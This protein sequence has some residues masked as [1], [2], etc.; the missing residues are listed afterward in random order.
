VE[1][2]QRSSVEERNVTGDHLEAVHDVLAR[3]W[4]LLDET[5]DQRWRL[6]FETA[7]AEIAAN[8]V[9]HAKPPYF[10]MR[11]RLGTECVIAEFSDSG[12]G[13]NGPAGPAAVL[14]DLA[15]E[16]G[17]GLTLAGAAVDEVAYERQ[18]PV[19]HWRLTKRL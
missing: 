9:E 18:G 17:R 3:F 10:T 12:K 13:W 19:N 14:D 11:I 15:A 7:V 5:P 6:L 1:E 16:R 4:S 2:V 8:I